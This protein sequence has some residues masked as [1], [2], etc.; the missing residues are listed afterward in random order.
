MRVWHQ[1]NYLLNEWMNK[2]ILCSGPR[3][4]KATWI[5]ERYRWAEGAGRSVFEL[6]SWFGEEG[7]ICKSEVSRHLEIREWK[8]R[9]A[10]PNWNWIQLSTELLYVQIDVLGYQSCWRNLTSHKI[11]SL[12]R[13]FSI[14]ILCHLRKI[15]AIQLTTKEVLYLRE[16]LKATVLSIV[17]DGIK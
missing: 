5:I 2:W 4:E 9:W 15:T 1:I 12:I 16:G 11:D 8:D 10:K 6:D 13:K 3:W 17:C 14:F 7:G